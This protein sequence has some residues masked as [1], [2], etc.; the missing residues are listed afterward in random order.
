MWLCDQQWHM[1]IIKIAFTNIHLYTVSL[2]PFINVLHILTLTKRNYKEGKYI[3]NVNHK[4]TVLQLFTHKKWYVWKW[5]IWSIWLGLYIN[6][7]GGAAVQDE[8]T[9]DIS[10]HV[11]ASF[12][13]FTILYT[14]S[15]HFICR[16]W[17]EKKLLVKGRDLWFVVFKMWV[18][19]L[20]LKSR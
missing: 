2:S 7:I 11:T 15:D 9:F 13:S 8:T 12:S 14:T 16:N 10:A 17:K 6:W 4:M 3:Y 18:Y 1:L 19:K 5:T 20:Y